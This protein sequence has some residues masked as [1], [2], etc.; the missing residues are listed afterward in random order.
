MSRSGYSEDCEDVGLWRGAVDR[1]IH[2][3][4]GQA[5]LREMVASLDAL[6]SKE[7]VFGEIVRDSEHVC[8]LGSVALARGVDVSE[9]DIS[10]G[11]DVGAAFGIARALACEIAYVN[12]EEQEPLETGAERWTRMRAWAVSNLPH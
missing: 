8:A 4:R 3:K 5:F 7:L 12:D 6:P 9:L 11:D 1:A 10:D 2:G